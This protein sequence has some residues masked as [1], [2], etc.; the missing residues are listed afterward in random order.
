MSNQNEQPRVVYD[1]ETGKVL[2]EVDVLLS[3]TMG[4]MEASHH[5]LLKQ[6][7]S[8]YMGI[9]FNALLQLYNGDKAKCEAYLD[10]QFPPK[11]SGRPP[12]DLGHGINFDPSNN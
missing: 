12:L 3:A 6:L 4:G 10:K 7:H 9:G 1:E 11:D 5:P 8:L 2:M